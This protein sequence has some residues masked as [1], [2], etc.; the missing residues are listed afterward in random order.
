MKS[1]ALS[2]EQLGEEFSPEQRQRKIEE[3]SAQ[4][5]REIEELRKD[6][7]SYHQLAAK[8]TNAQ[9]GFDELFQVQPK[10]D[11]CNQHV[12]D[13]R[14]IMSLMIEDRSKKESFETEKVLTDEEKDNTDWKII[15]LESED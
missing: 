1:W 12:E 5:Q 2:T 13:T 15:Q 14:M 10:W 8:V 6:I 9:E 11:L 4:I 3:L 7:D